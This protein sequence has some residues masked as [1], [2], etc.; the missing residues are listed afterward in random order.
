[1]YV[2]WSFPRS[3]ECLLL[4]D[5]I[6]FSVLFW[7][8][9]VGFCNTRQQ[10]ALSDLSSHCF[11]ALLTTGTD[12]SGFLSGSGWIKFVCQVQH[13][14]GP[15]CS[16][17]TT[18]LAGRLLMALWWLWRA[19]QPNSTWR[20]EKGEKLQGGSLGSHLSCCRLEWSSINGLKLTS[21]V[22]YFRSAVLQLVA[23]WF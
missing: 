11:K 4:E 23:V 12:L 1:M 16:C 17:A 15:F 19:L 3:L 5:V 10:K 8:W 18:H 20:K 13:P 21:S 9:L 6:Y 7:S 14:A 2:G 22:F